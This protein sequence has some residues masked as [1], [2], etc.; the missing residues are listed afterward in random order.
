[1]FNLSD[2]VSTINSILMLISNLNRDKHTHTHT[3]RET[4]RETDRDRDDITK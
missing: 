3:R 4:L 1:M 2:V